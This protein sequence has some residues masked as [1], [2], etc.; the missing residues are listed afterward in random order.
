[1]VK[2][3]SAFGVGRVVELEAAI[4]AVAVDDIGA[5]PPAHGIG[6]FEDRDFHSVVVEMTSRG[7]PAQPGSDDDDG[8]GAHASR[9]RPLDHCDNPRGCGYLAVVIAFVG[10]AIEGS[11]RQSKEK[12]T[13]T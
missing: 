9:H 7:E 3:A 13:N 12:G 10:T 4:E 6:G 2:D 8:H 11:V 1:M 5:Y